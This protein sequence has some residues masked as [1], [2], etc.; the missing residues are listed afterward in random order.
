MSTMRDDTTRTAATTTSFV[1][2]VARSAAKSAAKTVATTAAQSA[3]GPAGAAASSGLID[4]IR[5]VAGVVSSIRSLH[6]GK[7]LT[8]LKLARGNGPVSSIAL[9]GVGAMVG[10]GASLLLTDK[11]GAE[12]RRALLDRIKGNKGGNKGPEHEAGPGADGGGKTGEG[13]AETVA[14]K[15]ETVAGKV[16]DSAV[17]AEHKMENK[18]SEKLG[19]AKEAILSTAE[20]AILAAKETTEDVKWVLVSVD[21]FHHPPVVKAV[22]D[23]PS[24]GSVKSSNGNHRSASARQH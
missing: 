8:L 18:V 14:G 22:H 13:K 4:G 5:T 21:P 2:G 11:S 6:L 20:S 17:S 1:P 19:L 16:K 24:N 10:A 15:A 3:A 7:A 12:T 23:V 9:F